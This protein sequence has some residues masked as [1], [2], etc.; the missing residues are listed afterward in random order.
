VPHLRKNAVGRASPQICRTGGDGRKVSDKFSVPVCRIHHRDL[1]KRGNERSWW[2]GQDIDPLPIAANL[3]LKSQADSVME[4]ANGHG[5]PTELNGRHL[6]GGP[7]DQHQA[8]ETKPVL[9]RH[10]K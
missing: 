4:I 10:E 3:W 7:V 5:K 2:E 6:T 8:G 1:H 9:V